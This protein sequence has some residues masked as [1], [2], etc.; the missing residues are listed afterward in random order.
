MSEKKKKY[1]VFAAETHW[2][3]V[4][5]FQIS[6]STADEDS[7]FQVTSNSQELGKFIFSPFRNAWGRLLCFL[8]SRFLVHDYY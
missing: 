5:N 4:L 8:V 7:N 6:L 3:F 1:Q 2:K